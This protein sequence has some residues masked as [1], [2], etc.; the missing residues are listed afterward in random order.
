VFSAGV[1]FHLL[2]LGHSIFPGKKYNDVLAQ[3][4]SCDFKFDK[5]EYYSL[6][7]ESLQLLKIMLSKDPKHRITS[8]EALGQAYFT[9]HCKTDSYSMDM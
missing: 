2:L 9:T 4:R 5:E 6:S 3:N 7:A 1:I 8:S